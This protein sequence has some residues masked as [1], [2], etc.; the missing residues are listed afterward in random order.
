[1]QRGFKLGDRR[2]ATLAAAGNSD[3][4]EAAGVE[5]A[6]LSAASEGLLDE[7]AID[8]F[9][10]GNLGGAALNFTSVGEGSVDFTH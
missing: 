5:S 1:M 8:V 10:L 3:V 7:L 9:L 6:S 4:D 2:L